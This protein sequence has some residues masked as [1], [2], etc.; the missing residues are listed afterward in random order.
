MGSKNRV[1]KY[2]APV[3]QE[4]VDKHPGWGYVE[5]MVG[6]ANMIDKIKAP[7]RIGYD[8]NRYLIALLNHARDYPEDLPESFT[9]EEYMAVKDNKDQ[10]PDWYVGL[11]GFSSFGGRFFAGYAGKYRLHPEWPARNQ[12][13]ITNLKNQIPKL[14][15]VEFYCKDFRELG[16]GQTSDLL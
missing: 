13:M 6:G 16:G 10:Y 1:S 15:G 11:I 5:P 7:R 2:L 8:N 12:Q 4:Q 9:R 14:Q 3:I